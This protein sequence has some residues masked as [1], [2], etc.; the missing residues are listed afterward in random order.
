MAIKIFDTLLSQLGK[1]YHIFADR[2][3]TTRALIDH[4]MDKK[5]Y[6][7]GTVQI[8]RVGF[9]KALKLIKLQHMES[10]YWMHEDKILCVTWKDK[11]A[12]KPV[13]MAST[14]AI[15]D[16]AITKNDT[17]KPAVIHDYN[18][19]MNGC[20]RAD[21]MIGYYGV[22]NRKTR[23]WWKK[24]FYWILEVTTVNAFILHR[25]TRP[26]SADIKRHDKTLKSFKFRLV[27]ELCR[28]ASLLMPDP[29]TRIFAKPGRPRLGNPLE[30][31][32]GAKHCVVYT[33]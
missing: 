7:T 31:L 17:V 9:P 6:Y 13:I 19:N 16:N 32:E 12:K 14:K 11:K 4:L 23:K 26:P 24:I 33:D 8:N 25:L 5:M 18:F 21:Q 29:T 28:N 2:W 30:R 22:H 15:V 20:D 1:G 10:R 27:D 3:Y